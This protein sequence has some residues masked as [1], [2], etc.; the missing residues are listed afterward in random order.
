M[1]GV[2]FCSDTHWDG[3]SEFKKCIKYG[4][5]HHPITSKWNPAE[6]TD[7]FQKCIILPLEGGERTERSK[8]L[9]WGLPR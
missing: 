1:T 4:A 8:D 2:K 3:Q 7:P 9:N 5:Y 6:W